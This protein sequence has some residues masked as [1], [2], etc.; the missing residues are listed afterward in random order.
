MV[1]FVEAEQADA[2]IAAQHHRWFAKRR[3]MATQWDGRTKFEIQETDAQRDQRLKKWDTFLESDGKNV[4]NKTEINSDIAMQETG[5]TEA[6]A[7]VVQESGVTAPIVDMRQGS[8][9]NF[10]SDDGTQSSVDSS[11]IVTQESV[12]SIQSATNGDS[13]TDS[14]NVSDMTVNPS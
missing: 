1:Y 5:G 9:D 14:E 12:D 4:N 13:F 2:F 3:I 11:A 7:D 6:S 8:E 10:P